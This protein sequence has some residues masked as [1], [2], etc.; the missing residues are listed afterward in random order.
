[1]ELS[2]CHREDIGPMDKMLELEAS[3]ANTKNSIYR[4]ITIV[5]HPGDG[6]RASGHNLYGSFVHGRNELTE[7][8][9]DWMRHLT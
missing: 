4:N 8:N 5:F 6:L 9:V 2:Q 3:N 7:W 1:M